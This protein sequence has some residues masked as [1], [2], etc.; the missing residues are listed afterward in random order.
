MPRSTAAATKARRSSLEFQAK[1]NRDLKGREE[2]SGPGETPQPRVRG[3]AQASGVWRLPASSMPNNVQ[4]TKLARPKVAQTVST[5]A[6]TA[7]RKETR[8]WRASWRDEVVM[9]GVFLDWWKATAAVH[10]SYLAPP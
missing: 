8:D 3:G 10:E 2:A 4:T 1:K 6:G 9:A 5:A 7:M